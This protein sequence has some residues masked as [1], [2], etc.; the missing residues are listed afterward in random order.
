VV[1]DQ[2]VGAVAAPALADLAEVLKDRQHLDALA[3]A[4]R[5]D[6]SEVR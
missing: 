3:G 4:G 2:G 6:L 5:G 1:G